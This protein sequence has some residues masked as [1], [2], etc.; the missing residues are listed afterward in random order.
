MEGVFILLSIVLAELFIT[1]MMHIKQIFSTGIS[2]EQCVQWKI[3][4]DLKKILYTSPFCFLL[5]GVRGFI[6]QTQVRF[7]FHSFTKKL[8]RM[9]DFQNSALD[10]IKPMVHRKKERLF[11]N[12]FRL[13]YEPSTIHTLICRYHW[14]ICKSIYYLGQLLHNYV[15]PISLKDDT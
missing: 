4:T 9:E 8:G 10:V 14:N 15:L 13:N 5:S 11:N 12:L 1:V 6:S 7:C 3:R 2:K